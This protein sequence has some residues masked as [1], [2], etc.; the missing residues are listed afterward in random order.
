MPETQVRPVILTDR[1]LLTVALGIPDPR[2]KRSSWWNGWKLNESLIEDEQ[3]CTQIKDLFE[4]KTGGAPMSAVTWEVLK[5][6][7][8]SKRFGKVRKKRRVKGRI[9]AA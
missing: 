6:T 3:L 1:A 9:S 2:V 4:D 8:S 7:S 5:R